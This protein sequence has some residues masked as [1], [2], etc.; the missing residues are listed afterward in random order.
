MTTRPLELSVSAEALRLLR[1]WLNEVVAGTPMMS[2]IGE[3]ELAVHEVAMNIIDHAYGEQSD[4]T[5]SFEVSAE[6]AGDT[7]TVRLVDQGTEFE[8]WPVAP[9]PS[10][11]QVRGYGMMIVDQLASTVSHARAG[12][13][14]QWTLT[15][16]GQKK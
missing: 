12:T 1:P 5:S 11:P 15:F 10:I 4:P 14:N 8:Q 3:I 16:D 2:Q 13:K 9:D 6:V 7:L